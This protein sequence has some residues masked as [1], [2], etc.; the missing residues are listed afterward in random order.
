MPGTWSPLKNQPTF[1]ASTM[2]LLTD[3]A[4]MC[5]D[6][7]V[8]GTAQWWKLVPAAGGTY[9]DGTWVSLRQGPNKPLYFASAVLS[10]GRV[11]VAG[12]EFNGSSAQAQLLAAEI[13]DPVND[14]WTVLPT[15]AGWTM[16]GDA[17]ACV[18]PDGRV[19]LGSINSNATAIFDPGMNTWAAAD[20]KRNA[21]STEE[22]WTLLP[23]RTV[24]TVD[25]VGHPT[26]ERYVV[27]ADK[28]VA[29]DSLSAANDLVEA[30]SSEIGPAVLL[31]DGR[32][33]AIG[34]TG[35]TALYTMPTVGRP[36][37]TW[38][39]GPTFPSPG[40]GLNLGAKDAPACLLP[41]GKVLCAVA[42]VDG[43][44]GN[45]NSPTLFFEFEP[46]TGQLNRV[47]DPPNNGGAPFEGRMLLL[48]TGEVLFSN[49][50]QNV[51]V[52]SPDGAPLDVWRPVVTKHPPVVKLGD[53]VSIGGLQLN[54]LSQAVS[55]GDD[56]Q[57]ATNYPLV[58]LRSSATGDVTY[59]RTWGHSSMGVATGLLPQ[60]T[61]FHVPASLFPGQFELRVIA[62]GISSAPVSLTVQPMVN[63]GTARA[64]A[65][66]S[67]LGEGTHQFTLVTVDSATGALLD[68]RV[69]LE[70]A[71][72][73]STN[74]SITHTFDPGTYQVLARCPGFM[75]AVAQIVVVSLPR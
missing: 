35:S 40:P 57:M 75:D 10:D 14:Q 65:K 72:V 64:T 3:G 25:C 4:V 31:P 43:V 1:N 11:F 19:L 62:N 13:Y 69:I 74:T 47:L 45:F 67:R 24:L 68:G 32:V 61:R 37:G 30:S 46:K 18:L 56:A 66:P 22:T 8:N 71:D 63:T 29:L 70:G 27:A 52:Y 39:V 53:D 38:Q 51:Q 54:G 50:S 42:T 2:L 15:P 48:P 73:G 55:Y 41:N 36:K 23:D 21:S 33:F 58:A 34:A 12:G 5:H 9:S 49:G 59:C 60:T 44:A 26:T 28:W 16:I 17:P 20:T 7:G 6:G